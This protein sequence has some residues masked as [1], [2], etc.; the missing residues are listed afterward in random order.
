MVELLMFVSSVW[1]SIWGLFTTLDK[2]YDSKAIERLGVKM[3]Q[4]I[5]PS[6]YNPH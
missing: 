4:E 5:Y 2:D 6:K 1:L 3:F